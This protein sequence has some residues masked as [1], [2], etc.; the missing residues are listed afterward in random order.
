VGRGQ[1][2]VLLLCYF[3]RQMGWPTLSD[4][5]HCRRSAAVRDMLAPTDYE[6]TEAENGE[7]ALVAIAK[8]KKGK[9]ADLIHTLI[10]RLCCFWPRA[11]RPTCGWQHETTD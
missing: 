9:A 1:L 2:S 8:P 6:I 3:L 4:D 11:R 7:E 5:G 10:R